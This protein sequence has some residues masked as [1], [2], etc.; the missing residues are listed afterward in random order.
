MLD[1]HTPG[2]AGQV[3]EIEIGLQGGDASGHR[4][5]IKETAAVAEPGVEWQ[6][7]DKNTD[8][9]A[10]LAERVTGRN[11]AELLSELF[12]AFGANSDGSIAL[13]SD[14]T[15][16][17]SYGISTTARDF[18]LFHQWIAQGKAP[19]SYYA[20]V[21]DPSKSKFGENET[22]RLLGE[23]IRYGSQ[24]YYIAD[25]DVLYSSGSFGQVGYSDLENGVSVVFLQDWAVNAE[26]EKFLE[27][28]DRALAIID[29]LRSLEKPVRF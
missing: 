7:S 12:D 19:G 16:S 27:T 21:T 24:S 14:G 26:L 29:Y 20:S 2:A 25:E 13:T 23:G 9:L 28:R 15:T 8:L 4:N 11:Y 6:Y 22:G 1:F 10:L 5:A 18:A 3:W 17:P